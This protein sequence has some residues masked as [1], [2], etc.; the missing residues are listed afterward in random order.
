[1]TS[2]KQVHHALWIAGGVLVAAGIPA[3]ASGLYND[4]L[5]FTMVGA[6][7]LIAGAVLVI[8]GFVRRERAKPSPR[9]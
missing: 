9:P 3:L 4:S 7:E 8:A 5:A 6:S 2:A 1:M